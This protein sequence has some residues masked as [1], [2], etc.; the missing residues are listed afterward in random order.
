MRTWEKISQLSIAIIYIEIETNQQNQLLLLPVDMNL[1]F[2][3]FD[4]TLLDHGLLI[5]INSYIPKSSFY[6]CNFWTALLGRL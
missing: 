1:K 3:E 6:S 5:M 4:W 2:L